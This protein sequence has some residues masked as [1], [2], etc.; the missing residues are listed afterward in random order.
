MAILAPSNPWYQSSAQSAAAQATAAGHPFADS[1]QYQ[2]NLATLSSQ[3]ANVISQLQNDG[4][5][6][7]VMAAVTPVFPVYLTSRAAEQGYTPEWVV[8]GVALTDADIVGQLFQQSE[9]SHAFGV[10]FAGPVEAK[11]NTFGYAAYKSINPGSEPANAVD[12]IYA[13][14]YEMAIGIEMAGPDLTPQNFEAGMRAYPGSQAGA[15]NALY[16]T[17]DFPTGHFTPQVDS[18]FI[19]WDPNK[20]SP[21]TTRR[22]GTWSRALD[23]PPASTP[24][25]PFRCRPNF[26]ITPGH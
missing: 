6:T 17:W 8:A 10:T 14:M 18:A 9:W 15:S 7:V 1:I 16:G 25:P 13:Q 26:P 5:T 20:V 21:I 3:A 12:I 19:Y 2:L 24:P 22:A 23:T 4:I 11:Q